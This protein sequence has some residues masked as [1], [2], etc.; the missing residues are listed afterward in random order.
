[1]LLTNNSSPCGHFSAWKALN[2]VLNLCDVM[3]LI[4]ATWQPL[5]LVFLELVSLSS[6]VD[7][8]LKMRK[9]K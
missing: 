3:S 6:E 1:M 4:A 7:E 8:F 2:R 5:I 9:A